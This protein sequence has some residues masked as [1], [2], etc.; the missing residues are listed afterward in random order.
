MK[1]NYENPNFPFL[2]FVRLKSSR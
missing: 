1:K 2:S